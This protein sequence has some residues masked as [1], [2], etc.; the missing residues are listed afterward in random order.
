MVLSILLHTGALKTI[1]FDFSTKTFV[2]GAQKNCLIETVILSTQNKSCAYPE[3][4]IGGADPPPSLK[5]HENIGFFSNTGLDPLKITKLPT[6][7]YSM[8]G[9]HQHASET[10]CK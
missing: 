9:H 2:V 5:N 3:V 7:Q 6:S 4:G 1:F 8:F 10:P